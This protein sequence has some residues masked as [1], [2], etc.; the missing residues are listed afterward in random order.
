MAGRSGKTAASCAAPQ[1]H[2]V[3]ELAGHRLMGQRG[4]EVVA[5]PRERD[6]LP[7]VLR[8]GYRRHAT[9]PVTDRVRRP[10]TATGWSPG[11]A[12]RARQPQ[13]DLL[14]AERHVPAHRI[15]RPAHALDRRPTP[16]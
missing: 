11:A 1:A 7:R 15:R 2:L 8:S 3:L 9:S 6:D 16:A 4:L 14:A 10:S 13:R 5:V 12:M